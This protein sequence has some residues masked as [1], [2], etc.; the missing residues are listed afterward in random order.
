MSNTA[1]CL[2]ALLLIIPIAISYKEGLHIIKDLVVASLR[3]TIQLLI[4]GFLL[5]YIFEIDATWLLLLA[6]FII[7]I[8]ASWNTLHRASK[9]MHHVFWI[10]LIAIIIGTA[11]PLTAIILTGAIDFKPNEVIPI[12]GMLANNGLIAINLA[13]QHL[14][15]AFVK[16]VN[17]IESKL[18]LAASPKLA[19]KDAVRDS[20]RLAIVP[21]IDSVKTYGLVSIPGM[22]TGLIIGGTPPLEAVKFQLLVVFVHTTSTVMSALIAT[23]LSYG[24]FFNARHQLVARDNDI[25]DEA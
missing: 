7:I 8:N 17:D 14:D 10:S 19:S 23:Y 15:R 11:I 12:S 13:Y 21:T 6:V 4:L 3:A 9:V 5:H 2:T 20:I 16:D 24:Q 1:I 22:M 25:V 18:T